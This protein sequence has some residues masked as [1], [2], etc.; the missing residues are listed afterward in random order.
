MAPKELLG[1]G[2]TA[3]AAWQCAAACDALMRN[4]FDTAIVSAVGVTEQAI[5]VR[6]RRNC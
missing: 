2:F 3:A 6:F 5:G 1:E 4:E